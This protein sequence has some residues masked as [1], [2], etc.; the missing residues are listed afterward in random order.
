VP[1]PFSSQKI[2]LTWIGQRQPTNRPNHCKHWNPSQLYAGNS[3]L[4]S[5]TK[6]TTIVRRIDAA[7]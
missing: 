7:W 3:I 4:T 6:H 1:A 2:H 5:K